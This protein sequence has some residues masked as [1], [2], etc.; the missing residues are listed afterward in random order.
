MFL[1]KAVDANWTFLASGKS[2]SRKA[3]VCFVTSV[4][5]GQIVDAR[6]IVNAFCSFFLYASNHLGM[7]IKT[8]VHHGGQLI[9]LQNLLKTH[10]K[11]NSLAWSKNKIIHTVSVLI[12]FSQ[13]TQL[14]PSFI[15]QWSRDLLKKACWGIRGIFD[16]HNLLSWDSQGWLSGVLDQIAHART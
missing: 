14:C 8:Q 11:M 6:C 9:N 15:N 16:K 2:W 13:M 7:K 1:S 10:E 4:G 5:W 12:T 3:L